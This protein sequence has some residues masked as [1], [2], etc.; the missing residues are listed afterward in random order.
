MRAASTTRTHA[1]RNAPVTVLRVH[2][3]LQAECGHGHV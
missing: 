2:A 1:R 3:R